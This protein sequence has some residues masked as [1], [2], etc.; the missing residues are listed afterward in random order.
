MNANREHVFAEDNFYLTRGWYLE[1][2]NLI[3]EVTDNHLLIPNPVKD[4]LT[5][6]I[7]DYHH[8]ILKLYD[9]KGR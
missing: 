5:I 3:D 2:F 9:D 4:K 1:G 8:C 7:N 6:E